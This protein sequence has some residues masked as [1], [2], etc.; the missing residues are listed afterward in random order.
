MDEAYMEFAKGSG[1]DPQDLR[2]LN[3]LKLVA[4]ST[5]GIVASYCVVQT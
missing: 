2:P 5:L 1:V 4:G 3:K